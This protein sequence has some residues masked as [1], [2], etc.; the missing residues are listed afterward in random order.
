LK[1]ARFLSAGLLLLCGFGACAATVVKVGFYESIPPWVN[2]EH[3]AGIAVELLREVMRN[4]NVRI[5]PVFYPFSRRIS[6]Y[7]RGEIDA[8]YDVTPVMQHD[9]Q[10]PGTLG[11]ALHTFD[12]VVVALRQRQFQLNSLAELQPWRVIAWEGAQVDVPAQYDAVLAIANGNYSELAQQQNQVRAL[13]LGRCD[14]IFID[15]LIFEWYRRKLGAETAQPVTFYPLL[16]PKEASV[17]WRDPALRLRYEAG[18]RRLKQDGRYD[19]IFRSYNSE[20]QP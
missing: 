18:L 17:L 9:Y 2:A 8:L 3:R 15:R 11:K 13:Y 10:L 12:N 20:P 5:E 7:R 4:E 19:A 14:V 16:A 6:A 1:I